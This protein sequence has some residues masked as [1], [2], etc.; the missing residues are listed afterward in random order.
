MAKR[1]AKRKS[2][3]KI[4]PSELTLTFATQSTS[5]LNPTV[6]SYLD[7]SQVASIVNR[8]FYRQGINWAV[9]GFKILTAGGVK[10]SV[11]CMRLPN[12]WVMSNA[13]EKAFRAWN[14]QQM[15][16]IA[17]S[18]AESAVARFRDFKIHMDVNHVSSTFANNLLPVA[19][20]GTA[21]VTATPGEWQQS[22]IVVPNILLD[23]GGSPTDPIEYSLHAVGINNNAGISRGI[24]EGYADSRAYPQSPDPVS[25]VIQSSDNWMRDMFDVGNDNAEI[26]GNATDKNDDLPYPQ[27]DYPGGENQLEGLV[28]HDQL[29]YTATTIGGMA[30]LKGGNFPCG[31]IKIIHTV[32]PEDLSHNLILQVDLVPGTH[33]GYLCEPMTEM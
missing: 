22:T 29:S 7:L 13:W 19:I 12:S 20:D 4:E 8:R 32:Q 28:I 30:Y 6:E 23:A 9:S 17:D 10:G 11:A 27:V 18:G 14:K 21:G 24:I 25:P 15:D 2:M 31:L 1:K 5:Q 26:T 3:N 33:R 16:A